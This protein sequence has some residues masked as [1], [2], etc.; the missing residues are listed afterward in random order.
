MASAC[1]GD[2]TVV[3]TVI[4]K[5]AI[6]TVDTS[7]WT[8]ASGVTFD[9]AVPPYYTWVEEANRWESG[10]A[11]IRPEVIQ[12][13]G[14]PS[15]P[16]VTLSGYSECE[17]DIG[18]VPKVFIQLGVTGIDAP[19]GNGYYTSATFEEVPIDAQGREA[20]VLFEAFTQ[21]QTEVESL[22]QVFFTVHFRP[23]GS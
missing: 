2:P 7:G 10:S 19:W 5:C 12:P 14:L 1:I 3:Q 6:P 22:I 16:P 9:Y 4:P 11:W 15:S 18:T 23:T 17:S 21:K 13:G 8:A 20:I